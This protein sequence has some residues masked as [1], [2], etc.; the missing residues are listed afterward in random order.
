MSTTITVRDFLKIATKLRQKYFLSLF[1]GCRVN[2]AESNQISQILLNLDLHQINESSQKPADLIIINT[3]SI[4]QKGQNESLRKIK[5]LKKH[6]PKA[7]IVVT[8]CASIPDNLDVLF[9]PN[10]Q[11]SKLLKKTDFYSPKVKD[12]LTKYHR[13]LLNIQSGCNQ[14]CSYCIVPSKRHQLWS[15]PIH[16]ALIQT[17]KALDLG[18]TEIIIT[19]ANLL[20]TLLVKT[21]AP[22]ISFG[23]VPLNC[24]DS[25]F[26]NLFQK[27]PHRLKHFLHIPLQ[28]GSDKILKLMHRPYTKSKILKTFKQCKTK[29][30][31]IRFGTDIIVGFPGESDQDFQETYDL[32]QKI[33]F[34]KIHT[35]RY[36]PRPNTQ[37][38]LLPNKVNSLSKKLRSQ[39]IRQLIK[40]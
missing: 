13:Y 6:Y 15:L 33:G 20:K 39:H 4:T 29:I 12:R 40:H 16:D 11:K 10:D 36:S 2:A 19:G 31:N 30:K 7:T 34:T 38:A 32:C 35:F 8:G 27:Y 23:S 9:L 14:F 18:F 25:D 21:K 37:A 26:I 3:C 28:S 24:I 1:F 17:K 5:S 22:L